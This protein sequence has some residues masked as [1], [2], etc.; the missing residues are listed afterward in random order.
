M[1]SPLLIAAIAAAATVAGVMLQWMLSQLSVYVAIRRENSARL[2]TVLAELLEIRHMLLVQPK[3][4][5]PAGFGV[6]LLTPEQR[7]QAGTVP[8]ES[9]TLVAQWVKPMLPDPRATLERYAAAVTALAALDPRLSYALRYQGMVL[10]LT[11]M[12]GEIGAVTGAPPDQLAKLQQILA[13]ELVPDIETTILDIAGGWWRR[14]QMRALMK[15][16]P[17]SEEEMQQMMQRIIGRLLKA[18]GS[19]L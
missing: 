2:N 13:E 11:R 17:M 10:Q 8:P 14:R 15:H 6:T 5:D 18:I 4:A 3:T 1:G 12:I 16:A 9:R 19:P 7:Q